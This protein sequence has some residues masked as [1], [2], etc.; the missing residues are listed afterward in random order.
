MTKKQSLLV[1]LATMSLSACIST[2]KNNVEIEKSPLEGQ[3]SAP[4]KIDM[5]SLNKSVEEIPTYQ[6]LAGIQVE[7]SGVNSAVAYPDFSIDKE[8]TFAAKNMPLADFINYSFKE[9]LEVNYLYN[10]Q[11]KVNDT[12]TLNLKAKV[13]KQQ[14]FELAKQ[15]LA[16]KQISIKYNDGIFYLHHIDAKKSSKEYSVGVGRDIEDIPAEGEK[17]YQIVPLTFVNGRD[18]QTLIQDLTDVST[19][20]YNRAN[21]IIFH[22]VQS[23][24]ARAMNI[25][26]ILD[27]PAANGRHIAMRK[28]TYISPTE[29][30]KTVSEV[31]KTEGFSGESISGT[32]LFN[33]ATMPRLK[34]VIIHS[35]EKRIVERIK[36]WA[37][38]L[39]I[40]EAAADKSYLSYFPQYT[41]ASE[42]SDAIT[43]LL[44]AEA[45]VK[46][47][48][49]GQAQEQNRLNQNANQN[50]Q[51]NSRQRNSNSRSVNSS[52]ENTPTVSSSVINDMAVVADDKRNA[53]I[54]YTEPAKYQSLLPILKQLDRPP[55]QV[56]LETRI[57]EVTLTE[58]FKHGVE[59]FV[60][61]G[62]YTLG[63]AGLGANPGGIA[64]ALTGSDYNIA[65]SL[66]ESDNQV[67]ILSSPR[68][69]VRDGES[70]NINV[71]SEIPIVV[72]QTNSIDN[73]NNIQQQIQYRNTGVILDVTPTIN[74]QGLVNMEVRQ[75]VSEAGE[76]SVPGINSPIILNRS[77]STFVSAKSGQTVVLGGLISENNSNN[78]Q[79]VPLLGDIP[80]LGNLF[81]KGSDSTVRTE[82]VIMITPKVLYQEEDI[83]E[84]KSLFNNEF[85]FLTVH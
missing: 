70:A 66:L 55:M 72:G 36:F 77:I 39:D 1:L 49:S 33:I 37:D 10:N 83:N 82:L 21:A 48:A 68:L 81:Q 16:E 52:Q 59:W 45:S 63:T 85:E 27:V 25:L 28:L 24:I 41:K 31:L 29:F 79:K 80:I 69:V 14:V 13:S 4:N 32:N 11:G 5:Q 74:A 23:E 84:L 42:L 51:R 76:D 67:E 53:L 17:A 57:V 58:E 44:N 35:S 50:Q 6:N 8:I 9:L 43:Q 40:P 2:S 78:E 73:P 19:S 26:K 62:N 75:E 65:I 56:L 38:N 20:V 46:E 30:K 3:Q 22:G 54:F 18:I 47:Q 64:W 34:A 60:E 61:K 15:A 12:I 71:G 7:Q